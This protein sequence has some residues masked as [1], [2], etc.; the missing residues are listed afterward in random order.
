MPSRPPLTSRQTT[1]TLLSAAPTSYTFADQASIPS[2]ALTSPDLSSPT[3]KIFE[4]AEVVESEQEAPTSTDIRYVE[5][6]ET[7]PLSRGPSV[8]DRATQFEQQAQ[9]SS[10]R[11][12]PLPAP[13]PRT[14]STSP[15]RINRKISGTTPTHVRYIPMPSTAPSEH[16]YDG[17][18]AA[19]PCVLR[20]SAELKR[21]KGSAKRMIQ[22]WESLPNT[23]STEE[24]RIS[25]SM[26]M[27][28]SSLSREYLDQKP[29]PVPRANAIPAES[30]TYEYSPV[31]SPA[32]TA[33]VPSPLQH[34]Q[35]PS[36]LYSRKRSST[37]TPS[38]SSQSLSP[39]P[40]G[41]KR[42]KGGRSPLKEILNVFGGGIQAIG[43]RAK[44]KGK[45]RGR[46]SVGTAN[47]DF[48]GGS[49]DRLGTNGLPGGIV[50]SDR[51]GDQ[52]MDGR[53][54]IDPNVRFSRL[55]RHF[56]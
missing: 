56:D 35:T 22:Q 3:E 52:E 8:R 6:S 53:L 48:W 23:P 33:Y 15:L 54:S 26:A 46:D 19:S 1:S 18:D 51:M 20:S 14:R 24:T 43:R 11:F 7:G 27:S 9:A 17:S 44:G 16:V 28:T 38:P 39:S 5:E 50:F 36:N 10:S 21:G 42:K 37:L 32:R 34:L 40:S 29:L 4:L 41:D 47:E 49:S 45:G 25:R 31:R 30:A 2:T 55:R 12:R 13:T